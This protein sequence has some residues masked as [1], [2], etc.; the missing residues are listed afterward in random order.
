MKLEIVD[1]LIHCDQPHL[2]T[3]KGDNNAT[4]LCLL[5]E[6][7]D[8]GT[9]RYIGTPVSESRMSLFKNGNI[10]VRHIYTEPETW[11][12]LQIT[13]SLDGQLVGVHLAI[14]SIPDRYLPDAGL[15]QN[16]EV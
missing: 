15:F 5:M 8:Q 10:D 6:V 3:A 12:F 14:K 11:S 13:E 16:S 4:Y 1:V 2:F 9:N 7:S